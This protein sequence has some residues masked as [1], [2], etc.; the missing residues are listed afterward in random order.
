[1]QLNFL[2][3]IHSGTPAAAS[4]R[5]LDDARNFCARLVGSTFTRPFLIAASTSKR[6]LSLAA[7]SSCCACRSTIWSHLLLCI[8][9]LRSHAPAARENALALSSTRPLACHS[10]NRWRGVSDEMAAMPVQSWAL[11]SN[12]NQTKANSMLKSER[13]LRNDNLNVPDTCR[14][15]W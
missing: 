10:R 12:Q 4:A 3:Q 13:T 7:L 14:G 15:H 11:A 8:G 9:L 6:S 2:T 5:Y 1:M